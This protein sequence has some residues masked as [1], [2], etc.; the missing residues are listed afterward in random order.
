MLSNTK[1]LTDKCI[2]LDIDECLLHTCSVASIEDYNYI[3]SNVPESIKRRLFF[4][5][6]YDIGQPRGIGDITIMWG[7][8]RP[9]LREFISFAFSYFDQVAIWSAGQYDYVHKITKKIFYGFPDPCLIMTRDDIESNQQDY[10]K[11]L[12][13]LFDLNSRFNE[14]NTFF[15]DDKQS[16]FGYYHRN[17]ITIPRYKPTKKLSSICDNQHLFRET[18]LNNI[19]EKDLAF[20]QLKNWFTSEQ[21]FH[22]SDVR[23]LEKTHIFKTTVDFPTT[24]EFDQFRQPISNQISVRA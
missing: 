14:T 1:P 17:G 23:F 20:E 19:F 2:V 7:I 15:L 10:S 12:N 3:M 16:N 21:V 5:N 6:L 4:I 11:P 9:G 8:F 24:I 22:C 13:K 18:L